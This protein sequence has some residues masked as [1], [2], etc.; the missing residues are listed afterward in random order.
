VYSG[1][2][3]VVR[4]RICLKRPVCAT[5]AERA[6]TI[7]GV[8]TNRRADEHVDTSNK[9][10]NQWRQQCVFF[11]RPQRPLW[12]VCGAATGVLLDLLEVESGG[13]PADKNQ[14]SAGTVEQLATPRKM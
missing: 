1:N 14:Y 7:A 11:G 13:A 10:R 3:R 8:G 9:T 2:T 5:P 4:P 6:F 12:L